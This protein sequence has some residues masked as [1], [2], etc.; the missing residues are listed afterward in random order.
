MRSCPGIAERID[1]LAYSRQLYYAYRSSL[2]AHDVC[3]N[4][5][6]RAARW[7]YVLRRTFGG[8]P[9][10]TKGWGYHIDGN[11]GSAVTSL[12]LATA[13]L[14]VVAARFHRVQIECQDYAK[15]IQ[16]YQTPHTLFY[17]DPPYIG[18]EELYA[19][20]GMQRF[21]LDDH[22]R[23]A[24]LLNATPALVA[25]SYYEHPLIHALYP[26]TR[27]RRMTWTQAKA[28]E[29]APLRGRRQYGREVLLMN[30]PETLGL[31]FWDA[32]A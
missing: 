11:R 26:A 16:V 6:E 30:Y 22:R 8:H 18:H 25:L 29:K 19:V 1:T 2:R 4:D 3:L 32:L 13:L 20:D 24:D 31:T 5:L 9:G 12:R 27:W 10:G 17:V 7:F 23:L 21:T 14:S 15:V 28:V